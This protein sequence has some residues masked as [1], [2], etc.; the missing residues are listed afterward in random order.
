MRVPEFVAILNVR[1]PVVLKVVA[2][3]IDAVVE[4]TLLDF[5]ELR[6][7]GVPL[8]WR[9]RRSRLKSRT[10]SPHQV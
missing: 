10:T 5:I 9:W 8:R 3:A 1:L 4:S 2:R 6:R 7:I